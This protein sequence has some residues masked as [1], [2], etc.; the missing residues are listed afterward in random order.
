MMAQ[1]GSD[2]SCDLNGD[3]TVNETDYIQQ[4][5]DWHT[6]DGPAGDECAGED[7]PAYCD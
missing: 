5:A 6:Y 3:D 2:G 1:W 4:Q 7:P